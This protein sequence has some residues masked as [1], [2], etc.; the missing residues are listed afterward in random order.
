M[1]AVIP[2]RCASTRFPDK[3]L[4]FIDGVPMIVRVLEQVRAARLVDDVL[5]AV[6]DERVAEVV[7]HAGGR[8]VMTSPDLATGSDRVWAVAATHD[9]DLI[10]N[11]QGDEPLMP[12]TTIDAVVDRLLSDDSLDVATA[13]VRTPRQDAQ[14]CDV[15]TVVLDERDR[16]LYFSTIDA[17]LWGGRGHA[18]SGHLRLPPPRARTFRDP[19][20]RPRSKPPSNSSN[21]G[22]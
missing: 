20:N 18:A 21:S 2:A 12:P 15:V 9:A 11:V 10:V 1:L 19:G 8:A 16:A 7:E 6:D 14:S 3:P 17:S 22:A 13:A 5:V 4:A